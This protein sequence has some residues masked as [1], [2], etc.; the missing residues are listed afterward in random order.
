MDTA[1]AETMFY[2][3]LAVI[4][5]IVILVMVI[6]GWMM[7]LAVRICGGNEIGIFYG[8]TALTLSSM[9][10]AAAS[11]STAVFLPDSN[12]LIAVLA[13]VLGSVLLLCLMLQM[14]PVRAFAVYLL[15]AFLSLVAVGAVA[16]VGVAGV[17]FLVPPES[18]QQF[19]ANAKTSIN[20]VNPVV[21][22]SGAPGE[23]GEAG[24]KRLDEL[25]QLLGGFSA[26]SRNEE[27][28]EES[29]KTSQPFDAK[30]LQNAIGQALFSGKSNDTS[31]ESDGE[32]KGVQQS[33]TSQQAVQKKPP[34]QSPYDNKIRSNPFVN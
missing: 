19:A 7:K 4:A 23:E 31:E 20:D 11:I 2:I 28:G 16:A 21:F 27:E 24:V 18:L 6:Q 30:S 34:I 26:A 9:A 22:S 15:Q 3:V 14:G 29:G 10:G 33:A 1:S 8:I 12:P 25:T 32:S 17:Y 5:V 13:S